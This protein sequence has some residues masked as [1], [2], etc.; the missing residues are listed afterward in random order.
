M[1]ENSFRVIIREFDYASPLVTF[2]YRSRETNSVCSARRS[3]ISKILCSS[4]NNDVPSRI[5]SSKLTIILRYFLLL[6]VN[7]NATMLVVGPTYKIFWLKS[8]GQGGLQIP[9]LPRLQESRLQT[10]FNRDKY[11]LRKIA[12]WRGLNGVTMRRRVLKGSASLRIC[13][14]SSGGVLVEQNYFSKN[15]GL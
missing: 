10:F 11:Y 6:L 8:S 13:S 3:E 9:T 2:E 14:Q 12:K 4:L 15:L 5:F 7:D 1:G